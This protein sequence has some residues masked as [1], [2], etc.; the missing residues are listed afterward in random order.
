[1]LFSLH[2]RNNIGLDYPKLNS[3]LDVRRLECIRGASCSY[4]YCDFGHEAKPC[5]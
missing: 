2:Y 5:L 1:M 4:G 3:R